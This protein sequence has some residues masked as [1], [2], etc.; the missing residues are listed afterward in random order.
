MSGSHPDHNLTGP[1]LENLREL[2]LTVRQSLHGYLALGAA[3]AEIRDLQLYRGTHSTFEDYLRE[4]WGVGDARRGDEL[5]EAVDVAD[6]VSKPVVERHT[7]EPSRSEGAGAFASGWEGTLRCLDADG[8]TVAYVRI[9]VDPPHP[10]APRSGQNPGSAAGT[11][12]RKLLMHLRWLLTQSAG[13]IADVSHQL[14]THAA[15]LDERAREQLRDDVLILEDELALL[16][17]QLVPPVD[18]DAEYGRL[19]AGEVPPFDSLADED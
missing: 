9:T 6:A 11:P 19:L 8:V 13:G 3:L 2:E 17:A 10:P 16:E 1:E 14:E 12:D 15:D 5:A 18:W 7:P 4:R